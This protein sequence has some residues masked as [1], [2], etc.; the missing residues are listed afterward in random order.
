MKLLCI[1][2]KYHNQL[3]VKSYIPFILKYTVVKKTE[4]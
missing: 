2:A 4:L 3:L 1:D